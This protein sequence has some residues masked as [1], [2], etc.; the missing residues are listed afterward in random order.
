MNS[1][2]GNPTNRDL[3]NERNNTSFVVEEFA[4]WWYG[5]EEKLKFKRFLGKFFNWDKSYLIVDL[6]KIYRKLTPLE[7]FWTV[8]FNIFL[9]DSYI[10]NDVDEDI[11]HTQHLRHDEIYAAGIKSCVKVS[12][13]L[14]KL[15]ELLRPG[16][17]DIWP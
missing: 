6:N 12:K 17:Q 3:Q 4:K 5:G 1:N 15:Q 7:I 2:A 13:K 14:R 8:I 10:L 9:S 16:Q 11:F